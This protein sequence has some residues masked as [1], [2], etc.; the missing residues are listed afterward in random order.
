MSSLILRKG[1]LKDFKKDH[2]SLSVPLV[3]RITFTALMLDEYKIL[4]VQ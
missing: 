4:T 3:V 1:K 2:A